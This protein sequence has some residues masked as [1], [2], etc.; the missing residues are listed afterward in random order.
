MMSSIEKDVFRT[1]A[2]SL[3]FSVTLEA[4]PE[5]WHIYI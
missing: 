2:R 3:G 4:N 5:H 1:L